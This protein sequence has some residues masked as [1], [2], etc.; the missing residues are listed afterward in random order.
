M[1]KRTERRKLNHIKICLHKKV[2]SL[3]DAGFEDVHL[4]H[5]ALP[6]LDKDEI[7]LRLKL[8]G[9]DLNAPIV[10]EPITGGTP[11]AAKINAV[12]AETAEKFGV[13]MGVGSQRAGI[14]NPKLAYTYSIARKKASTTL[15]FA[16]IGC[17]QLVAGYGIKEA[18]TAV[19][20]IDADALFIHLNPLQELTQ[21][22]GETRFHGVL[23]KIGELVD[24]IDVPVI[25]KETGAG[26]SREVAQALE[27]V[28]VKGVDVAG[29][30]GTSWAAVEYY[31]AKEVGDKLRMRLGETF[32]NWGIPTAVSIVE[33][34]KSTKL[35]VIASGGIRNGLH[36]AKSIA[37]G[38]QASGLA[39]PLLQSAAK[40][41]EA[42]E[43]E[44]LTKIEELKAAMFLTGSK[45]IDELK[46]SPVVI[47][48]STLNWLQQRGFNVED[49]AGRN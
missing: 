7:D 35:T 5:K 36:I 21:F 48:G 10:I 43:E 8:F 27:S 11:T 37:L 32:W 46:R 47:T 2:N 25:V 29:V 49:Y 18:R 14:E 31:R 44:L 6:E 20:M 38:A 41:R 23:A 12:L 3:S 4:V 24:E 34:A 45:N 9:H 19:E 30:G 22:E 17:A 15:L 33:V 40:G 28:G 39:R 16:N 13:A 26:I 42:L 1:L